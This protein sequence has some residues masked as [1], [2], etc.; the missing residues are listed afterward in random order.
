[1]C[2]PCAPTL[3]ELQREQWEQ[4]TCAGCGLCRF[5]CSCAEGSCDCDP[6]E[7]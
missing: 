6:E 7:E 4:Q 3:G 5:E 2:D 1:M